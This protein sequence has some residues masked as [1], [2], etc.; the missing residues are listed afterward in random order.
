ML[1]R[2]D[3]YQ[4][5]TGEYNDD[6]ISIYLTVRRYWGDRPKE[7]MEQLLAKMADRADHLCQTHI[8][9]KV[10]RPISSAIASRS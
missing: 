2:T 1:T 3:N 7:P 4:V 9:P 6:E 5:R 10:L 8:V